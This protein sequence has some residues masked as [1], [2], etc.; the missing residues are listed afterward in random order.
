MGL[1]VREAR[2]RDFLLLGYKGAGK[3]ALGE[4]LRLLAQYDS[5]L[6][7]YGVSIANMPFVVSG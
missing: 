3:S 4:H 5:S 7:V 6:F 1:V 2:G